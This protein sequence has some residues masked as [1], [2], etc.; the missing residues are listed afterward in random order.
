MNVM[1]GVNHKSLIYNPANE[2]KLDTSIIA[3]VEAAQGLAGSLGTPFLTDSR[4]P[5]T[6]LEIQDQLALLHQH[7]SLSCDIEAASLRFEEAGIA[8]ISF[9]WSETEGVAFAVDYHPYAEPL[10]GYHGYMLVNPAIRALLKKFFEEYNGAL[11]FH[12]ATYDTKVMIYELWMKDLLDTEGLLTGLEILYRDLHDT[13]IIAYLALNSTA[14]IELGLKTLAH[15]HAGNYAKEDIKNVLKI[16]LPELLEYNLVDACSTNYVFQKYYL[17]LA[18]DNQEDLYY[19][20]MLPS[21]KVITQT[22]LTGMPLN[23][24]TVQDVKQE[25][26]NIRNDHGDVIHQHPAVQKTGDMLHIRA[27]EKDYEDRKSKAKNPE[28]IKPKVFDD[29][30]KEVFN[31]NSPKQLGTLLYEVLGLPII[32]TTATK[33]PATGAKTLD[34][35]IN[36]TTDPDERDLM[37]AIIG[38]SQSEKIL[39]TFITA[40]EKAIDKGDGVVWLHGSFNLGGTVSGRLSSSN[41][42]LQN[43]PATSIYGKLV[44][45][46]FQAPKGWL[47]VGADFNSLEDYIS[48]L[49]TRDPNK[50]KVY[51]DGY[52]GH[53][54]RAFSYFPDKLP[55]VVDTV[56]SINSIASQFPDIRQDSKLPTFALTYQGTWKTL[57]NGLG[58]PAKVA[59]QIEANYH[60]L[61]KV[62]DAWVQAKLDQAAIDGYV[63]VAFGLR[64]RT[65]LLAQ[66]LRNHRSTPYEAAAEGRTA[67]NAL[68]QSYGL[69][70]NRSMN[71]FMQKVWDSDYRL[72][73]KPSSMIHDANYFVVRDDIH[74]VDWLNR[75]LIKSMQWQELP[76]LQHDLVKI[77][78]QLDIYYPTWADPLSIDNNATQAAIRIACDVHKET[79]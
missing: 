59:K 5:A 47:F 43:L 61:Y 51:L 38:Y 52:D 46:C 63:T 28:K 50:L 55:G 9:A 64:V 27:W 76:E 77:G 67:G 44:K 72:D 65:P 21:L 11:T 24:E 8:T 10:D 48:A 42:N 73:I 3:L 60:E 66:T 34:K 68:G 2:H 49:T 29:F 39:N 30:P 40:F 17:Q 14:D 41:P 18:H 53:C 20:M 71:E 19:D 58:L 69:L 62:S 6:L 45:K 78:A 36:H 31:T 12:N 25:L 26:L 23:P 4:Y 7:E 16:P 22:E 15:K 1:L 56:D 79:L 54:L 75:E 70:T 57:V 37:A 35:L 74:A 13:K 32:D 33:Q